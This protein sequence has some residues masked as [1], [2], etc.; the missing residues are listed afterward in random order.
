MGEAPMILER[1]P[2]NLSDSLGAK[3]KAVPRSKWNE[4]K[5]YPF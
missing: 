5:Q 4:L 1:L 2:Y 3:A